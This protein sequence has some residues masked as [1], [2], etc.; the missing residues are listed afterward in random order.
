MSEPPAGTFARYPSLA[1]RTVFVTGGAT[2]IGAE[3]VAQFA[4]QGARRRQPDVHQP[5]LDR[6]RRLD[7]TVTL[8]VSACDVRGR[9][10][11]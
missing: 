3:I 6:R 8:P 2:G 1:G 5:E 10:K 11:G 7:L 4:R 9:T